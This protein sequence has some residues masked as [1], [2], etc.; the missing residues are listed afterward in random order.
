MP[1]PK[2]VCKIIKNVVMKCR[3]AVPRN[4]YLNMVYV[5]STIPWYITVIT[6]DEITMMI[7]HA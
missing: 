4:K 7:P 2:Q 5:T 3:Y 6:L 1:T